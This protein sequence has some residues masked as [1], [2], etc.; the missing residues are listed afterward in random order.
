MAV[1]PE[2]KLID[3][4]EI[5]QMVNDIR[6]ALARVHDLDPGGGTETATAMEAVC[7]TPEYRR[8]VDQWMRA[9][10]AMANSMEKPDFGK[11]LAVTISATVSM[12]IYTGLLS[13]LRA[14]RIKLQ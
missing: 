1:A 4:A 7:R 8:Y 11:L 5:D 2:P 14:P 12:G 6:W 9:M 3:K 10:T 13:V